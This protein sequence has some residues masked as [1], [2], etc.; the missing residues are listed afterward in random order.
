MRISRRKAIM[1]GALGAFGMVAMGHSESPSQGDQQM[2]RG[3]KHGKITLLQLNDVHGYLDLHLEWFAAPH[4][5]VYR[6]AGGYARIS[7]LLKNIRQETGG[8][9]LLL[10][11]GDTFHGTYPVVQ[12]RGEALLPILNHLGMSAMT[13]HWDFAYG[14]KQLQRLTAGLN[15]PALAI[16]IYEQSTGK[17]FLS[18]YCVQETGGLK[19]GII[20]IASNIVDK[21][22]PPHFSEG[23]RFTDGREEL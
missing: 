7:T 11:N 3:N 12:S 9:L 20:G 18:P 15:Y 2:I 10:D 21:T 5:P 14:P 16:N 8:Q 19:I 13:V 6:R 4:E 17:R 22:M 1:R 23:L